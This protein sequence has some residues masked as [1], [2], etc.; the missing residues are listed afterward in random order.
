MKNRRG[1]I[2]DY[3]DLLSILPF[4]L[5]ITNRNWEIRWAN[6]SA[7]AISPKVLGSKC[8]EVFSN[9]RKPCKDCPCIDAVRT[10]NVERKVIF[11]K[12]HVRGPA[13]YEDIALPIRN[14]DGQVTQV[15]HVGIDI[16]E[17]MGALKELKRS[18][19]F[20][21]KLLACS[22]N[23]I[24][25][26]NPDTS[27]RYVNPSFEKLTGFRSRSVVGLKPP[28][29]WWPSHLEER[30]N[31]HL[32]ISLGKAIVGMDEICQARDGRQFWM[33]MNSIPVKE[34]KKLLYVVS[35]WTDITQMKE[36]QYASRNYAQQILR[37]QEEERGRLARELHDGVLQDLAY[38]SNCL[39]EMRTRTKFRQEESQGND[40]VV[41]VLLRKAQSMTEDVRRISH[42]LKPTLLEMLGLTQSI[43]TFI[44][45][46]RALN[47][48]ILFKLRVIGKERRLSPETELALF[49]IAQEAL[50]NV[51]KHSCAKHA[52]VIIRFSR[53]SISMSIKDD[54]LGFNFAENMRHY[55]GDGRLGLVS[56]NE[57]AH[58][59][60]SRLRIKSKAGSG[61]KVAV[62]VPLSS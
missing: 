40:D 42:G 36:L 32:S 17:A 62:T 5:I 13:F 33:K 46:C 28:F 57:R 53:D 21:E 48:E 34:G 49:R 11:H 50:N 2:I 55:V 60:N 8:Y 58:L 47:D 3:Q 44:D 26:Y 38:I 22:P 56:M 41:N 51:R 12:H 59:L 7:L 39:S 15:V 20:S 10:G 31:A 54:G 18:E 24:V 4:P 1:E 14:E 25:V 6:Q 23:I 35:N 43:D 30:N 52:D 37:V 29:P 27:I 19:R 61:T 9:R 16:T 45:E